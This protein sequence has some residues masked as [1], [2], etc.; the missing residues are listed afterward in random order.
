M[1]KQIEIK[2]KEGLTLVETL[3]AISILLI[4]VVGPM[5]IYSK[6][7]SNTRYAGDKIT[8]YYLAQ[9]GIEFIKY[10]IDTNFNNT[11]SWMLGLGNCTTAKDCKVDAVND[12]LCF[13]GGPACGTFLKLNDG[14]YEYGVTGR[15]TTFQRKMDIN[16]NSN[17]YE[18]VVTATV[19]WSNAT[20]NSSVTV[21]EN[22]F[23]WR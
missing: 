12:K 10:R 19:T 1:K 11:V 3:V 4:A 6:S 18:A 23:K 13:Q 7:I 15:E 2:L 8:A 5:T 14:L 21:K 22:V 17:S 20:G 9:E 16:I